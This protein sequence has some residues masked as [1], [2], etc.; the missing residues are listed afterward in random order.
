MRR[1]VARMLTVLREM[2]MAEAE[3]AWSAPGAPSPGATTTEQG[4]SGAREEG[5][6][7]A[8]AREEEG[9]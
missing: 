8:A 6:A 1:D 3:A 9:A 2:E 5:P 4:G 7:D